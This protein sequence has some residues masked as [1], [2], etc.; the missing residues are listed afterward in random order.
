MTGTPA[1]RHLIREGK[2]AQMY[3][4]LQTGAAAGMRTLDQHLMELV[5]QGTIDAA[6][7]QRHARQAEGIAT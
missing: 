6:E 1:I 3:S 4:S 7:A 5:R 2:V